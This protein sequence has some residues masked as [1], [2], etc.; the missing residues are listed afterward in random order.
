MREN[1]SLSYLGSRFH[2]GYTEIG[3]SLSEILLIGELGVYAGF[4]DFRYRGIG[5]K[6]VIRFN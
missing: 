6:A 1:I 5:V 4:D 3:Y 2:P